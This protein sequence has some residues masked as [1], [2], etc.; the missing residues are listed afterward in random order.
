MKLGSP[1]EMASVV[2]V[3]ISIWKYTPDRNGLAKFHR[4]Q[5]KGLNGRKEL[6]GL[7]PA[8]SRSLRR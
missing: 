6:P 1:A 8:Y 3:N 5:S 7:D 2:V 4:G